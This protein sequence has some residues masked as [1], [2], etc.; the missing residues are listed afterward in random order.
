[1]EIIDL[2]SIILILIL[3][4][5]SQILKYIRENKNVSEQTDH[6]YIDDFCNKHYKFIFILFSVII[7]ITV[8]YKFGELPTYIGVDEA[9][10]AYDA[11]NLANY[12]IDRYFNSYPVY[13]LN[14]GTGQSS[15]CA[16]LSVICIKIFGA[17]IFSYRL[18]TLLVYIV[19][20]LSSYLLVSKFKDKKTAL[21]FTF[22]IIT[23]P[24]D[25][26]NAREALDCNLYAG[27]LM[28]DLYLM[29]RA[30]KN[31]EYIIAGIT[32]GITLYTYCLTWITI[33]IFLLVWIV[34]M[35]Y[36]KKIKF[37]QVILLGIPIAIFA[38][39]LF[40]FLLVNYGIVENT[41]IGIVSF[42]KI[43]RFGAG[44][45]QIS[46][47]WE[48][49]IN[50][51]QTVFTS[52]NTI[53]PAYVMLFIIGYIISIVDTLKN[54]KKKEFDITAVMNIAFT[55]ILLGLLM[56]KIPTANK[57]NAL[58]IPILYFVTIAILEICQNFRVIIIGMLII[59]SI[60]FINF[61]YN[62]YTEYAYN[63]NS[64]WF[65]D[66][67]FGKLSKKL[68]ENDKTKELDKYV[69]I[70][71]T[72]PY[73]YQV[74]AEEISPYEFNKTIEKEVYGPEVTETTKVGK[75]HYYSYFY[76]KNDFLGNDYRDNNC[77]IIVDKILRDVVDKFVSEGYKQYEYN[78]LYIFSHQE[79]ELD[80]K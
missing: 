35:L 79:I 39:P 57:A 74:L 28:L 44:E 24:W 58:Y 16:Y 17:N 67:D 55:T 20:V 1:M 56:A 21:L 32:I 71:K 27:M 5:I 50:S 68:A 31:Y 36:M 73:I 76:S 29:N 46:N 7:F 65:E 48:K 37:S 78:S 8:I 72:S 22:F 12:G 23:C 45:I 25:I 15:L 66:N 69:M 33:P 43:E 49:G 2:I 51:I 53:Y 64:I 60:L 47:I 63:P 40:Y 26:M 3:I 75:Y 19:G 10:M 61:E 80:L 11:V 9:G 38:L 70:Y 4:G 14:F 13:L 42:P 18:P 6:S 34:Y 62:Y 54:I 77:I 59:I 41:Q 30:R 52:K